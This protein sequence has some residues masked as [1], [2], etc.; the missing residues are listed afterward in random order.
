VARSGKRPA[1]RTPKPAPT[2]T[3]SPRWREELV[4]S[5]AA[6]SFVLEL[7]MGQLAAYLPTEDAWQQRAP[8]W[9]RLL[10]PVLHAELTAWCQQNNAR[11]E[12]DPG[13]SIF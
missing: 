11:L 7:T 5:A 12:L 1:N 9:A 13:A 2:F 10:W 8:E 4:C 3:F 6:G